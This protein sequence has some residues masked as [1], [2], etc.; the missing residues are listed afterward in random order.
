MKLLYADAS[1]FAR[2][3]RAVAHELGLQDRIAL[4]FI[5]AVPGAEPNRELGAANPLRKI[6]TLLLD[7]GRSIYDSTVICEYLDGLVPEIALIPSDGAQRAEVMTEHALANGLMDAAVGLRYETAVRPEDARWPSW[8]ADHWDRIDTGLDWFEAN[9]GRLAEPINLAQIALG[10]LMGYLD[11]RFAEK[12]WRSNRP[13][14]AAWG[15]TML[16]RPSFTETVPAG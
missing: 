3:V 1:P 13:K 4:D 5:K 12:G 14:I 16:S 10:C 9:S 2:K 6:P 8:I 15:E 7:D 11:F